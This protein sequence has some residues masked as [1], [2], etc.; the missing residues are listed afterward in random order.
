MNNRPRPDIVRALTIAEKAALTSGESMWFMQGIERLGV[1]GL[2]V[3]DG[4]NGAR[5]VGI[6]GLGKNFGVLPLRIGSGGDLEP[7]PG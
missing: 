6:F 7:G 1:P 2:K 3:T 4:P 5:G